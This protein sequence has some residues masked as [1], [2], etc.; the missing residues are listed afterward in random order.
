MM[1]RKQAGFKS[2]TNDSLELPPR[3]IPTY[4]AIIDYPARLIRIVIPGNSP[5]IKCGTTRGTPETLVIDQIQRTSA[6]LEA[7]YVFVSSEEVYRHLYVFSGNLQT[8]NIII[9]VHLKSRSVEK[10]DLILFYKRMHFSIIGTLAQPNS[11]QARAFLETFNFITA[12]SNVHFA[13]ILIIPASSRSLSCS[14]YS[15]YCSVGIYVCKPFDYTS[16]AC[17][18]QE[19]KRCTTDY[20]YFGNRYNGIFP[21]NQSEYMFSAPH[22]PTDNRP[23]MPPHIPTDNRPIMPPHIPTDNR[24]IMPPPIPTDN[25]PI[26]PP[27]ISTD[28][29]PIMPPPIP[30]DNNGV[31][32]KKSKKGKKS[33]NKRRNKSNNKKSRK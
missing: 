6:Y 32:I 26:M 20:S 31:G 15:K 23:I 30:T 10:E 28:T 21:I 17:D 22:I 7:N 2:I 16:F 5:I 29:R 24:P 4:K 19:Q 27:H 18:P 9:R 25:R 3:Y 11:D 14:L 1:G 13:V 12:E 8:L 33:K